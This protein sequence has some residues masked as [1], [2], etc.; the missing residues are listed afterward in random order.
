MYLGALKYQV[1]MLICWRLRLKL[2]LG[3]ELRLRLRHQRPRR[4][5]LH[6]KRLSPVIAWCRAYSDRSYPEN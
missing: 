5:S 1:C 3:L 6:V 2:R 4:S